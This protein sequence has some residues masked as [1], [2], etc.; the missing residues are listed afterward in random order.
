MNLPDIQ[1]FVGSEYELTGKLMVAECTIEES[2]NAQQ[3]FSIGRLDAV[4]VFAGMQSVSIT[5]LAHL[6]PEDAESNLSFGNIDHLPT[7]KA[8]VPLYNWEVVRFE[9][10]GNAS[11][12]DVGLEIGKERPRSGIVMDR[13]Q[14]VTVEMIGYS[15]DGTTTDKQDDDNVIELKGKFLEG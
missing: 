10:Q 5:V 15:K 1:K 13:E 2:V 9:L 8:V 3:Y 4:G 14:L 11:Q 7:L 6:V 12:W